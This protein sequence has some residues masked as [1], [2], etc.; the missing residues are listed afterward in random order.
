MCS[1]SEYLL[2]QHWA[3]CIIGEP[4]TEKA[5]ARLKS[6]PYYE[7]YEDLTRLEI[8]ILL[9]ADPV[10]PARV[11]FIGSG[12]LPLTSLCFLSSLKSGI[13]PGG[14]A[15]KPPYLVDHFEDLEVLNIDHNPT[16]IETASALIHKLGPLGH[17]MSFSLD[18]AGSQCCDLRRF[19]VVYLAA[20]VGS[21]QTEKETLL[22]N[23][24]ANMRGG[25]L[26]V[27]RTSWGLRSC[28]YP[29]GFWARNQ[30]LNAC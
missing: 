22:T 19:D 14:H 5:L 23:V 4:N 20:L 21:T 30:G 17:G 15:A 28:L 26:I 11:A 1:E 13:F 3:E 24:A 9:A 7:N 18:S 10:M 8:G 25:A 12:P 27:M 16:A 29:V 2:E 6:F